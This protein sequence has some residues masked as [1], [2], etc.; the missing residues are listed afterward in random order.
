MRRRLSVLCLCLACLLIL[1]CVL[2]PPAAVAASTPITWTAQASG[3]DEWLESVTFADPTTGWVV[4]DAGTILHTG[5]AGQTWTQQTSGTSGDLYDVAFVS[6]AVG[7]VVGDDGVILHTTDGGATWEPQ[8]SGTIWGLYGTEFTDQSNGWAVGNGMIV[9]TDDGGLVWAKQTLPALP[10]GVSWF[11]FRSVEFASPTVGWAA[12][13]D[14]VIVHTD[15][16]GSTWSVQDSG[17]TQ[18]IEHVFFLD[19]DNGWAVGD[20][21]TLV[22][23]SD[24]GATWSPQSANTV[25]DLT[26]VWFIDATAGWVVGHSGTILR[27]ADGGSTWTAQTGGGV[28]YLR[29]VTFVN[30][31]SGW[32]VGLSGTILHAAEAVR[33]TSSARP[34]TV[35][36]N[37][38]VTV[39]GSLRDTF[40]TLLP[41]RALVLQRSLNKTTWANVK[42][43]ASSTGIYATTIRIVRKT[44]FRWRFAGDATYAAGVSSRCY[45]T[46]RASLTAPVTPSVARSGVRY[47]CYGYL[48]PQHVSGWAPISVSFYR[49]VSG[50]WRLITTLSGSSHTNVAGATRYS[51]WFRITNMPGK[52]RVRAMHVDTD[53]ARTYSAWRYFAAR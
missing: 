8:T 13:W 17:T 50:R 25:N 23:T 39:R 27:T 35:A 42:S 36:Y 19:T 16:G 52:W 34:A 51:L 4:G 45:A 24:G 38:R 5:D 33:L 20:A 29:G 2:S 32:A 43:V 37:G 1:P 30:A 12:G 10:P 21:G 41:G 26:S 48:R 7:W 18:D 44:F 6:T 40:G 46:S 47:T 22:H 53:H 11:V 15:D 3:T 31:T 28:H 49:Y 14:G 9:H